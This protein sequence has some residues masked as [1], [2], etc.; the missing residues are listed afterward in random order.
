MY[1]LYSG[2]AVDYLQ[3]IVVCMLLHFNQHLS[4]RLGEDFLYIIIFCFF[5]LLSLGE[6]LSV[7]LPELE[8]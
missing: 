6:N 3:N 2:Y 8:R 5:L 7:E 4:R 1:F